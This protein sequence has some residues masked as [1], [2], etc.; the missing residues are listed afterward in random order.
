[1][2]PKQKHRNF[3][4]LLYPESI[5]DDWELKLEV[6]GLPIVVSPLHDKDEMEVDEND[7]TSE[8]LELKK[9]HKL[10]KKPHYHVILVNPNPVT[11]DSVRKKIQRTLGEQSIAL[12]KIVDNINHLYKYLTHESADAIAKGKH[13]YDKRDMKHLN[14]FDISRYIVMDA[15]DKLE[16]SQLL[17]NAIRENCL[18]NIIELTD[19]CELNSSEG[20]PTGRDLAQV[21]SSHSYLIKLYMDA[22]YQIWSRENQ[23]KPKG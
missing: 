3:T 6:L 18:R 8:E 16:L 5:P 15:A 12:V 13:V 2:Q 14:N 20:Y 21:L 19:F 1:M 9:Q 22:A 4:F 23:N 7:L 10:F 17:I 11:A